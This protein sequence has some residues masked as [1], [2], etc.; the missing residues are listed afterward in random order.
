[1]FLFENY[2]INERK[3]IVKERSQGDFFFKI[4]IIHF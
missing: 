2:K 1:M 4:T 3:G